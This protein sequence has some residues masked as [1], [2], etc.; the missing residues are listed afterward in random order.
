MQVY[1]GDLYDFMHLFWAMDALLVHMLHNS[2]VIS[3]NN[4]NAKSLKLYVIWM[5]LL[6]RQLKLLV[7][8]F[9]IQKEKV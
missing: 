7:Q 5:T 8:L 6:Q 9:F 4:S 1:G 2:N 3:A